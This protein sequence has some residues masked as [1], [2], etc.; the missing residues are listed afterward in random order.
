M[1]RINRD[2]RFANDKTP[3][4]DTLFGRH[5]AEGQA[6]PERRRRFDLLFPDRG[7]GTLGIGAGEYLPPGAAPE[8]DP[9]TRGQR[10][11]RLC[12]SVEE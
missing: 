2:I 7:N 1:F 9:R 3:V 4:Q 5:H 12:E 8:S 6:P 10:C 11:D